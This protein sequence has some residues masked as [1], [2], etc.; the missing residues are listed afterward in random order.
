MTMSKRLLSFIYEL[1]T[2]N[3][4]ATPTYIIPVAIGISRLSRYDMEV[5]TVIDEYKEERYVSKKEKRRI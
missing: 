3:Y 2:T 1:G 5:L 4:K